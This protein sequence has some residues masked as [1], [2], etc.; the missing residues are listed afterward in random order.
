MASTV[1]GQEPAAIA[2]VDVRRYEVRFTGEGTP[3]GPAPR[4]VAWCLTDGATYRFVPG[5]LRGR[6]LVNGHDAPDLD[7]RSALLQPGPYAARTPVIDLRGLQGRPIRWEIAYRVAVGDSTVDEPAL[8]VVPWPREWP[9]QIRP[10][11]AATEDFPANDPLVRSAVDAAVG[12]PVRLVAPYVAAKRIVGYCV[13]QV[14][15]VS[16]RRN[17][18]LPRNWR[19][20]GP[21]TWYRRGAL[22]AARDGVGSDQ[23][24]LALC[25]ATLRSAGIPA[26][27]VVG[28]HEVVRAIE[29]ETGPPRLQERADRVAW[30]E[31]YLPGVGWVPFD[32]GEIRSAGQLPPVDRPWRGFGFV[33]DLNRRVPLTYDFALSGRP[34]VEITPQAAT[35]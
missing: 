2:A 22:Q 9:D 13:R 35:R 17:L 20:A 8:A 23:D 1:V 5:S 28:V 29:R 6:L 14:R 16:D 11:L 21:V 33:K 25:V 19:P 3:D 18:P 12:E 15:A 30:G 32:P 10:A 26:R 34:R 7:A 4:A 31:I 24:V 27:V